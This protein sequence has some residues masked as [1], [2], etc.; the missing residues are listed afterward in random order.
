MCLSSPQLRLYSCI[1]VGRSFT[2]CV[3]TYMDGP[4]FADWQ[5]AL[6][7]ICVRHTK[8]N[9]T[10]A[11]S[12]VM[13]CILNMDSVDNDIDHTARSEALIKDN[14]WRSVLD[15]RHLRGLACILPSLD[16]AHT[17]ITAHPE[18]CQTPLDDRLLYRHLA[19]LTGSNKS[20]AWTLQHWSPLVSPCFPVSLCL[21]L[22][23]P[24]CSSI[25]VKLGCWI[26]SQQRML[27]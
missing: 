18:L 23:L 4:Q 10:S 19:C 14:C 7:L 20:L 9:A 13:G 3:S 27:P 16:L 5:I 11:S 8:D 15:F 17:F 1:D 25:Q 24:S 26:Q 21:N 2:V 22:S 12:H 6:Y